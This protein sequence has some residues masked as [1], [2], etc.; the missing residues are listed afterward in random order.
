[1]NYRWNTCLGRWEFC[2]WRSTPASRCWWEKKKPSTVG[3]KHILGQMFNVRWW[4]WRRQIL[5]GQRCITKPCYVIVWLSSQRG[6]KTK[7]KRGV[8][9]LCSIAFSETVKCEPRLGLDR[10][11]A[12]GG[13]LMNK[14]SMDHGIQRRIIIASSAWCW[15]NISYSH[16]RD[17]NIQL[18]GG[19][20]K[21]EIKART[22]GISPVTSM[23][24]QEYIW[25]AEVRICN[26]LRLFIN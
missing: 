25:G 14:E 20:V 5:L 22:T 18:W 16:P 7:K 3:E 26:Y 2:D 4:T 15:I 11:N 1:M 10:C 9:G 24:F 8:G 17:S 12:C 19:Q 23:A 21:K 13:G 6:K